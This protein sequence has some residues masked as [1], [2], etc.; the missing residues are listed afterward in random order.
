MSAKLLS[1]IPRSIQ[2]GTDKEIAMYIME[3]GTDEQMH[4]LWRCIS[5]KSLSPGRE[6]CNQVFATHKRI[7]VEGK[8]N[9]CNSTG[10]DAIYNYKEDV[11]GAHITVYEDGQTLPQNVLLCQ[12]DTLNENLSN[13]EHELMNVNQNLTEAEQKLA[14]TIHRHANQRDTD[15][16]LVLDV[17][18]KA[19]NYCLR[20]DKYITYLENYC[21][22]LEHQIN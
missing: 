10:S 9:T 22:W 11:D 8:L 7:S 13:V 1:S 15:K 21:K 2:R 16:N 18:D 3:N 5:N 20:R 17:I 6:M 14:D 12:I 4:L 19:E